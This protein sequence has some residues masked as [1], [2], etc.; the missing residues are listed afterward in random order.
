MPVQHQGL[1][2]FRKGV[3]RA[4][5]FPLPVDSEAGLDL[6]LKAA[7]CHAQLVVRG[8]QSLNIG[9]FDMCAPSEAVAQGVG[10]RGYGGEQGLAFLFQAQPAT[11]V[12]GMV[13]QIV[14][15]VSYFAT[16][17]VVGTVTG[18]KRQVT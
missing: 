2:G 15:A 1:I 4:P 16:G 10:Q 14:V 7:A 13:E 12:P 17:A 5:L 11:Q 18:A 9:C 6:S 8:F 3:C